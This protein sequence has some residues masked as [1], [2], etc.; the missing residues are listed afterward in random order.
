MA[1]IVLPEKV[2]KALEKKAESEGKTID[3]TI[4][5]L[6][7]EQLNVSDSEVRIELHL[8]LCEKYLKESE[9]FLGKADYVQA[10]EKAW[11]AATQMLKAVAYAK[12]GR[13]L[14]SHSEL[15]EYASK[16]SKEVEEPELARLWRTAVSL[17]VNF[18]ENW[19]PG[20]DVIQAINE[21]KVFID[22][23]RKLI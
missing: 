18:Y 17:H 19:A 8:K 16:I 14:T 21:V 9:E 20:E 1:S 4:S 2:L 13:R 6:L 11:G 23:L 7:L 22:K 5:N 10:S 12:E 3:E 15:W